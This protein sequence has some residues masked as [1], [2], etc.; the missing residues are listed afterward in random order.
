LKPKKGADTFHLTAALFELL[1]DRRPAA[2]YSRRV[3]R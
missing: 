1:W 2:K 3:M